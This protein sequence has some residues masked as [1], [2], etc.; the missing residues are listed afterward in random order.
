MPS[1]FYPPVAK[2]KKSPHQH[3]LLIESLSLKR[4]IIP[5]LFHFNHPCCPC[6]RFA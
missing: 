4:L 5:R 1:S 2:I 6:L 3:Q